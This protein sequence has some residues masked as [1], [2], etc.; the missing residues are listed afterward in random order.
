MQK[1][2]A[3]GCHLTR[4]PTELVE[5]AGFETNAETRTILDGL[6]PCRQPRHEQEDSYW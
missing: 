1:V 6:A 3:D 4:D 2:V 5:A